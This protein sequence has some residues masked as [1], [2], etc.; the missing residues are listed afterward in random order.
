MGKNVTARRTSSGRD[1]VLVQ[2]IAPRHLVG[3]TG[4]AGSRALGDRA[5]LRRCETRMWAGRFP[6]A[7]LG[8]ITSASGP[9][10]VGLQFPR[11]ATVAASSACG[12]GLSPPQSPVALCLPC[13][14]RCCSGSFRISSS[15]SSRPIRSRP[16]VLGETNEVVL[17]CGAKW[18]LKGL[19]S[20]QGPLFW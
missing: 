7:T 16:F 8:W 20:K 15:G 17:V 2:Y 5:V 11:A 9:G 13:I 10:H 6:G 19:H 1:E 3:A 4:H 12:R 14:G 18:P